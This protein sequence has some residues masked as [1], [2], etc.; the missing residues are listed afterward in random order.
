[1]TIPA[2][3]RAARG[4]LGW[5]QTTLAEAAGLSLP[6]VKRFEADNGTSVSDQA[7][8]KMRRALEANGI[9]FVDEEGGGPGVRFKRRVKRY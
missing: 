9:L 5:S 6:T 1:M 7:M 8:D 4:L 2:Q 3:I